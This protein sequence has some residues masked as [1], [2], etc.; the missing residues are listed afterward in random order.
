[1]NIANLTIIP[2]AMR[3]Q[4]TSGGKNDAIVGQIRLTLF[5]GMNFQDFE[6]SNLMKGVKFKNNSIQMQNENN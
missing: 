3:S 6:I 2:G 1:M 5:L 4:T